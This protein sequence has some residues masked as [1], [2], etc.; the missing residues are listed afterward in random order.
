MNYPLAWVGQLTSTR[1]S[2]A[3]SAYLPGCDVRACSLTSLYRRSSDADRKAQSYRLRIQ[4]DE[5]I[6]NGDNFMDLQQDAKVLAA[7]YW[8]K[9]AEA[10]RSKNA[11]SSPKSH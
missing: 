5:I 8:L 7:L 1:A 9:T 4:P 2:C 10:G 3:Q 6:I 11:D